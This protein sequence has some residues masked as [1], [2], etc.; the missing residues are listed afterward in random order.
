[1]RAPRFLFY[2]CAFSGAD[3][4]LET[5]LKKG[6][7]EEWEKHG[8]QKGR[9]YAILTDEI[10][11]AWSGMT[12]R[13]CKNLKGLKKESLRDNRSDMELAMFAEAS[14]RDIF[15]AEKPEGLPA[16]LENFQEH[17][18]EMLQFTFGPL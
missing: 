18:P 15:K 13:K 8:V 4:A 17:F 7:T 1:M 9:E 6:Y 3:R 12:T 2:N 11:R 5:C 16:S 10:S 14:A